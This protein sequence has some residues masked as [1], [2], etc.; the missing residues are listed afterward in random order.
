MPEKFTETKQVAYSLLTVKGVNEEQRVIKGMASTPDPDRDGDIVEPMGAVFKDNV[1]LLWMHQ[2]SL[3]VGR[4]KFGKPT[5]LGIPFEASIPKIDAPSQLKARVD[6][7]WESVK[8]GLISAV[9]IGF[10]PLEYTIIEETGGYRFTKIDL[11]E[12]SLV[13]VPAQANA[14]IS[15]IK[16]LDR[17]VRAASG[18]EELQVEGKKTSSVMEKSKT[19][20][21]NLKKKEDIMS[22]TEKLKGFRDELETKNQ[23]LIELAEK[24]AED[25]ETF[26]TADQ[27]EFDTLQDEVKSLEGHIARLEIAEKASMKSAKPVTEKDGTDEK[28]SAETRTSSITVKAAAEKVPGLAFARLAKAKALSKIHNM[29]AAEVAKQLWADDARIS[30]ILSKAAVAAGNTTDTTW[31]A[32]LVPEEQSVYADFAEFLR[33][34]TILGKFGTG[35]T[36]A[37]RTVPF[38]TRLLGQSS[39]GTASWVGEG[40]AKPLTKF[41]FTTTSLDPLKVAAIAVITKELAMDSNPS[42]EMMVRDSLR[43]TI[44]ERLDLDFIDP[45]ITA[46][47]GVR[48]AS[49]TNG[50]VATVS[51]GNTA[52]DIRADVQTL[53]AGYIAANNA[54]TNGVIIM[55]STTALALSM[56]Q[57]PLGQNEF[58]GINMTGGTFMGFPTIVS[59]YVPSAPDSAGNNHYV[60]MVNASDI[61]YADGEV[62]VDMSDQAS[63]QM[64][65]NPTTGAAQMVSL[66]QHNMIGFLVE[67]RINYAKRRASAVSVLSGV[68]WGA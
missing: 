67:K 59:E 27:E 62:M 6:E 52:D 65:D 40:A 25:G 46:S 63:L 12:L 16:S 55:S 22:L 35:N 31:A 32:P 53:L 43:D 48:P 23:K 29:P 24:S 21:L 58:P 5:K 33:P 7:A 30:N 42:A 4:V 66:W 3:P 56:L 68:N 39:G 60:F 13:S 37:L 1:P 44:V 9:S 51:S 54:P 14:T 34:A 10:K 15:Q 20:K 64:V 2:H 47:A 28:K 61:Y 49:I 8:S 17:K 36:P 18:E 26:D 41:D 19:V 11:Y 38:R 57:N 45:T 50:V